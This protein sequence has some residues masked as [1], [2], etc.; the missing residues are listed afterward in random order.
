MHVGIAPRIGAEEAQEELL[1]GDAGADGRDEWHEA[2]RPPQGSI[3]DAFQQE[4]DGDGE[5][6][7]DGDGEE[8]REDGVLL[9]PAPTLG[10]D[11]GE[12]AD[13]TAG[14]EDLAM[15]EVDH[16]EDAVDQRIAE[17]DEGVDATGGE[18]E[19]EILQQR[20]RP[21]DARRQV[22]DGR[23]DQ[24]DEEDEP[25]DLQ[26]IAGDEAQNAPDITPNAP[27]RN[28]ARAALAWQGNCHDSC[29]CPRFCD[30]L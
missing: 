7:G 5:D 15:G 11:D 4:G 2:R 8:E 28:I 12:I 9:Q 18:A 21:R 25:G 29:P 27:E 19:E 23:D 13:I 26:S 10:E 16:E 14:H 17:G 6:G 3:G 30:R 1:Q 20:V 22:V 24:D